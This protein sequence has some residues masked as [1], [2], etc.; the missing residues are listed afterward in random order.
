MMLLLRPVSAGERLVKFRSEKR[1]PIP[2]HY[3]NYVCKSFPP[4]AEKNDPDIVRFTWPTWGPPASCRPQVGPCWPHELCY[5]GSV[6]YYE[7]SIPTY[8]G[9]LQLWVKVIYLVPS[10]YISRKVAR[11]LSMEWPPSTPIRLPILPSS[12]ACRIPITTN[13]WWRHDMEMFSTIPALCK[14]NPQIS[15]WTNSGAT[16]DLIRHGAHGKPLLRHH[17]SR[18]SKMLFL[19][20]FCIFSTPGPPFS[21]HFQMHVLNWKCLTFD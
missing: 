5:Q 9:V 15:W 17:G 19:F 1:H 7:C 13:S 6:R 4:A 16:G 14:G 10:L 18:F 8:H 3:G 12:K 11:L 21:W 20:F 2:L